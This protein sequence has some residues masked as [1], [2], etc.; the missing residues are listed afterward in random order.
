MCQCIVQPDESL[1]SFITE[2]D[3]GAAHCLHTS[4]YSVLREY[5]YKGKQTFSSTEHTKKKNSELTVKSRII[6]GTKC[7]RHGS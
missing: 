1:D 4:V 6:D 2:E 3:A 5:C 7:R